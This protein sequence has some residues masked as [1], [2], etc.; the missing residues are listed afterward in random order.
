M[1]FDPT[2]LAPVLRT[3]ADA[4][5]AARRVQQTL[6]AVVELT[7]DDRSPVTVADFAVQAI[8][9]LDLH[10]LDPETRIVGE[11]HAAMLRDPAHTAM[12]DAVL[13]AVRTVR[14]DVTVEAMID[15]IDRCDHD[16]TADGYWALDPVDGTKGFLRGQ[17]YAIALGWIEAGVVVAGVMGCPNL[18]ADHDG[19]L[20]AADRDG[21]LYAAVRG[22]GVREVPAGTPDAAG[23]PITTAAFSPG[24]T[25]RVC[26]SVE[27]A[28]SKHS[29]V[30][31]IVET[32]GGSRAPVR[33]DS[34]CKY[35]VVARGQADAYLRLPTRRTYVE[36][37][38]DHAAGSLIATE[39]GA[40]V[41][42][43]TGAPLDFTCG[44]RLERNR[45]IVCAVPEL[46]SGVITAIADLGIGKTVEAG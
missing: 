46:H 26:E 21:V 20:D 27:A 8:V 1:P 2:D 14:P 45:G 19:P 38:W 23:R 34:Q 43:I 9:S 10:T 28:H 33:L 22:A 25:I 44:A 6:D 4:V 39:A 36:K 13:D 18:P 5:V 3:V 11:E 35:A 16:G 37:I 15:A 41:T 12:R 7:K 24:G 40:V 32:L 29:D 30:A 42:D 17:Q 31:D